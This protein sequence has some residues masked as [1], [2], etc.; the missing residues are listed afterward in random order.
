M[1]SEYFPVKTLTDRK[2]SSHTG[3]SDYDAQI[4]RQGGVL[5]TFED[6]V[7]PWKIEIGRT[8]AEKSRE[9]IRR[10]CARVFTSVPLTFVGT[11]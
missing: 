4:T 7:F 2:E 6:N 10:G 1:T 8:K 9:T 11:I 3:T 5:A